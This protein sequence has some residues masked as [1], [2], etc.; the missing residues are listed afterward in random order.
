MYLDKWSLFTGIN[1]KWDQHKRMPQFTD[2]QAKKNKKILCRKLNLSRDLFVNMSSTFRA[3]LIL[4]PLKDW[5]P[6]EESQQVRKF[7]SFSR[8]LIFG[9]VEIS[10]TTKKQVNFLVQKQTDVLNFWGNC[11]PRRPFLTTKFNTKSG[12]S[13]V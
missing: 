8:C 11:M 7:L 3:P 5:F 13:F 12:M 4:T 10:L 1:V 6:P 2:F 9:S